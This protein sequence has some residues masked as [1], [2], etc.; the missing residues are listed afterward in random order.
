MDRSSIM[1]NRF[2][3]GKINNWMSVLVFLCHCDK[4]K[5]HVQIPSTGLFISQTRRS[6]NCFKF[7]FNF[8]PYLALKSSELF[9]V[10][11]NSKNMGI[12]RPHICQWPPLLIIIPSWSVKAIS[13]FPKTDVKFLG[14]RFRYQCL[15][16]RY[17]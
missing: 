7:S 14:Y 10:S 17:I 4:R 5:R 15:R 12:L 3:T 11:T 13:R 2:T 9:L 6:M 1:P 8:F 16:K